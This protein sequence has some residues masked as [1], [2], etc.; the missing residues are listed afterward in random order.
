MMQAGSKNE[1]AEDFSTHCL[2]S[3]R[4]ALGVTF[5]NHES[6][7]SDRLIF[8]AE[9]LLRP[10]LETVIGGNDCSEKLLFWSESDYTMFK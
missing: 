7:D 10:V 8:F 2:H 4:A 1:L 3:V 9:S 6:G 5:H